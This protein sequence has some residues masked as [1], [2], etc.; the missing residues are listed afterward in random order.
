MIDDID[1]NE[2]KKEN[3]IFHFLYQNAN[4]LG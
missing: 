1:E 4:F 3:A 2:E